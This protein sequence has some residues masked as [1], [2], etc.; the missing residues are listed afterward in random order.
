M[1]RDTNEKIVV[2]Y[3]SNRDEDLIPLDDPATGEVSGMLQGGGA[4]EIDRAVAAAREAQRGWAARIPRERGRYLRAAAALI[5]EHADEIAELESREMGKPVSQARK[6]DL[7]TCIGVFEFFGGAVEAMPSQVRDQG[8]ALDLTLLEPHGVVGAIVPFNWP[9]IHTAGKIAPALAVGNAIVIKPPEQAP[10]TVMRIAELVAS[11]LPDDVIHVVPGLGAAGAAL[12][13]HPGVDKLSFT[14][15]PAT[16]AN[17]I[18]A[19]ANN[20]TPTLMELGGKNALIVFEDADLD[21]ALQ[22]AVE[23]GWFNQ[24]EACTA[25]SRILVHR[26]VHDE[27]VARLVPAVKRLRVGDGADPATHVGPLV[28]PAQQ[29]RVLGYLGLAVAEGAVIAATAEL[30]TDPR[31]A[32]GY[33]VAPCLLTGVDPDMRVAREEIFGP[34]VTVIPFET[35]ED[36]VRIANDTEFGLTGA[37]YTTDSARGMRVA[38]ALNVGMV[39]INNYNR[40][41]IGMPFGG[42]KASG[43]GREHSLETLAQYGY[44]KNIRIPS[45]VAPIPVWEGVADVLD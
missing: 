35:E 41:V 27:L 3:S 7:E 39:W 26:S 42:V 29:E 43:Y 25:T 22:A 8:F 16:G 45:G 2:R 34:V 11:A 13:G 14:G 36:A 24:G 12:S 15:S 10:R 5:R 18:R 28:T 33:F 21:A 1:T 40:M 20:L 37:I 17:V 4:D 23:G 9:P 32:D 38:R 19:S 30:P 44:T 6:F 31:L